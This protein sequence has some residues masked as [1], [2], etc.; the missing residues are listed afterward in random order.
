MKTV[1]QTTNGVDAHV[2]R[3]LLAQ[4]G[5]DT[6]VLGEDMGPYTH[7]LGAVRVVVEP[8]DEHR[9]REIV[10]EWEQRAVEDRHE[11][12]ERAQLRAGVSRDGMLLVVGLVLLFAV[13]WYFT[14]GPGAR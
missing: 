9:A 8:G 11:G 4:S 7:A 12:A 10:A 1:Y 3:D 5:I 14:G 13:I 2:V 6:H